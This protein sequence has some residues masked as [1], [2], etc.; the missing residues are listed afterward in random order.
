MKVTFE[1]R[2]GPVEIVVRGDPADPAVPR[3]LT[4]LQMMDGSLPRLVLYRKGSEREYLMEPARVDYFTVC[5]GKVL[6]M[7]NGEAYESRLRLYELCEAL[8]ARGFVQISKSAVVNANAVSAVE[9]EFSGNYI[10]IMRDGKTRLVISR[11]YMRAF[12]SYIM[13]GK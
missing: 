4:A 12:R 7:C 8:R 13:E 6:A 9:A 2:P 3:I 10:A 5:D 11:S 1:Q